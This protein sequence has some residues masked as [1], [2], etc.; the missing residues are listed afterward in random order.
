VEGSRESADVESD[1]RQ[2]SVSE[3][4]PHRVVDEDLVDNSASSGAK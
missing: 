3:P 1:Q 4:P 2:L